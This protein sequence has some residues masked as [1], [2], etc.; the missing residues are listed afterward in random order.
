MTVWLAKDKGIKIMFGDLIKNVVK[1]VVLLPKNV[2]TG[3][4]EGIEETFE[5]V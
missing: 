5:D 1:E 3:V 2:I 4:V